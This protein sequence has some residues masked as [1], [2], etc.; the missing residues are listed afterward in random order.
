MGH[1]FQLAILNNQRVYVVLSGWWYTY[2][3]EKYEFVSWEGWHPIYEMEN[4]SHV[5]NLPPDIIYIYVCVCDNYVAYFGLYVA[6]YNNHTSTLL[7]LSPLSST[8]STFA[9][10][11]A[12]SAGPVSEAGAESRPGFPSI[13]GHMDTWSQMEPTY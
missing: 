12:A 6:L 8:T 10:S 9:A 2:P 4:K 7:L 5:W 3:S 11:F 1:G 13:D